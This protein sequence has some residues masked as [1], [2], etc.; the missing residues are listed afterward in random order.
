MRL[1]RCSANPC[2]SGEC[3]PAAQVDRPGRATI[4]GG[5]ALWLRRMAARMTGFEARRILK[6]EVKIALAPDEACSGFVAHEL[7]ISRRID[8]MRQESQWSQT[9]AGSRLAANG[10]LQC[11]SVQGLL[12]SLFVWVLAASRCQAVSFGGDLAF[13]PPL[14]KCLGT[15]QAPG[16][17]SGWG[18]IPN[19][20]RLDRHVGPPAS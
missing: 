19:R 3:L 15:N 18:R 16:G 11:A 8:K 1:I 7:E 9:H 5:D 4:P 6:G 12:S 10:R 20:R 17:S 14:G 2:L 13:V